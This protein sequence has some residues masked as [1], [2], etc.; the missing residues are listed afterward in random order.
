[1]NDVK[2][3]DICSKCGNEYIDIL[4]IGCCGECFYNEKSTEAA[5]D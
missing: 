1:M 3:V 5:N 2:S 4:G